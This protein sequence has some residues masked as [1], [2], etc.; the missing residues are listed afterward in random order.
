M[1]DPTAELAREVAVHQTDEM[2]WSGEDRP[3]GGCWLMLLA[4]HLLN[5]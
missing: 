1:T 2:C 3:A 5:H 4:E